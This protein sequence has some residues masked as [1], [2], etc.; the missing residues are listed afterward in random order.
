[1]NNDIK[2]LGMIHLPGIN[3]EAYAEYIKSLPVIEEQVM[4]SIVDN[5][6]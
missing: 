6:W 4:I 3:D 5:R 2:I 1:M